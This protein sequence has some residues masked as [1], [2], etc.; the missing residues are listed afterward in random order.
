[1]W[2]QPTN[3]NNL[4]LNW[5]AT[6]HCTIQWLVLVTFLSLYGHTNIGSVSEGWLLSLMWVWAD[7]IHLSWRF[8]ADISQPTESPSPSA[9][10]ASWFPFVARTSMPALGSQ[11]Q[12]N[13]VEVALWEKLIRV[14]II[15]MLM[16]VQQN[17]STHLR[18]LW[19]SLT[20]ALV[21]SDCH[22]RK[23]VLRV[24]TRT[25]EFGKPTTVRT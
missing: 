25:E 7:H 14:I 8:E 11:E 9:Q 6:A 23:A 21:L 12:D 2:N 19:Y 4:N 22:E 10:L 17:S 1:M 3:T 16:P 24:R 15:N 5:L 18:V 13:V 20:A